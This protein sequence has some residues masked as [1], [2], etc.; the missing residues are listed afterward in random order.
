MVTH[1]E[2]ELAQAKVQLS[3]VQ[4]KM[5]KCND[6]VAAEEE[7]ENALRNEKDEVEKVT[8]FSLQSLFPDV[9]LFFQSI[10]ELAATTGALE[11]EAKRLDAAY[12]KCREGGRRANKEIRESKAFLDVKRRD[13]ETLQV[14]VVEL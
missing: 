13:M 3:G 5:N 10:Q 9:Q 6:L 1:V 12:A 7:Q 2:A 14:S 4:K 11:D 8:M